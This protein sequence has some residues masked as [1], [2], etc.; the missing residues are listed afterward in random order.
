MTRESEPNEYNY[1]N[2]N[3]K[4][5]KQDYYKPKNKKLNSVYIILSTLA[6]II[7][8]FNTLLIYDLEQ[9]V[10]IK[11]TKQREKIYDLTNQIGKLQKKINNLQNQIK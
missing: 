2:K 6:I 8:I 9:R 10:S 7:S 11:I 1:E 3:L 5:K 4:T